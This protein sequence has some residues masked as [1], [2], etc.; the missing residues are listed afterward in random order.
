MIASTR[1]MALPAATPG[2]PG[3]DAALALIGR[4]YASSAATNA[5]TLR[6]RH[7]GTGA[8]SQ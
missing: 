2:L 4:R 8:I 1:S 3:V 6:C 5:F 7:C